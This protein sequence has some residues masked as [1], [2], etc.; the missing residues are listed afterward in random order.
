MAAS[1]APL[2]ASAPAPL[3]VVKGLKKHFLLA[4]DSL[5]AAPRVLRAVDGVDLE[6]ARGE[7]LGVVGESGCG[8]STL[9][10]LIT[11]L[12]EP[13]SGSI[14]FDGTDITHATP[15]QIRPLRRRMQM[16]FQDPYASLN[17]RMS[18]G[19]ILTGP[20]KLH[21]IA[22]DEAAARRRVLELLSLVG[23]PAR[24][25]QRFPHE[26]S[27]GQRQRIS[28]ARAL[29]VGP[30]LV[31]ADE[32]ISALDVNIQAQIINLMVDLQE[33]LGLTYLF[34]AHD[35]A[36]IRHVCD[37]IVVLYLGRV[38]EMAPAATLFARPLHPYTQS[39]IAAAPVPDARIERTRRRVQ[40]RGEPASPI[41]PPSGCPFRTRC[42]IAQPRCAAEVPPIL[43]AGAGQFVAC[44][45]PGAQA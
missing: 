12:H 8:K 38:M 43:D 23:L 30:D 33:R 42:P 1:P 10:R 11:R 2:A 20:L 27:G 6:V 40:L 41:A 31:V 19:E 26:F 34:I 36:V 3:L 29:S 39:L 17:P 18:V 45:F 25:A 21:G 22:A 4:K 13:T 28:I 37:R 7:T 5:F 14:V 16:I 24:A 9:A 44:H 15:A 32:P 35:L